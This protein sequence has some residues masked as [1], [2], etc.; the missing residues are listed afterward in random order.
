VKIAVVGSGIAGLSAAW[1]M[2]DTH[3]V[4]LFEADERLGGHSNTVDIDYDGCKLSVDTGF[5]VYNTLNY[6]NL[7]A[8]FAHLSV[9]TQRADMSFAFS[10]GAGR[11]WSSNGL[12]GVFAWRRNLARFEF[13]TMLSDIL[14]FS[15]RARLDLSGNRVDLRAPLG[16]YLAGCRVGEAFRSNYLLPMGSAIWSTPEAKLLEFPAQSFLRFFNN[17]RLFQLSRP[18]WRSVAGG[19]RTY[20]Q[21]MARDLGSRVHINSPVLGVTRLPEGVAI[22]TPHSTHRFDAAVLAGHSDQSLKV[23]RNPTL[24]QTQILSAI[25]FGD[26]VAYLHRDMSFMPKRRAAW[27]AWNYLREPASNRVCVTYWMNPLQGLPNDKPVFVTLNPTAPPDPAQTFSTI[28]Y[29][30][31][32]FDQAALAAQ[33]RIH[34]IQGK[35]NVWFA[36]AWLGYGFHEDGIVSG[37]R[38]AHELGAPI[39]WGQK[40]ERLTQFETQCHASVDLPEAA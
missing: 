30:H 14:R 1:A 19:S 21:R 15:L 9:E 7:T 3:D 25:K 2:R 39:P 5:I 28:H 18:K 17:H 31:P 37:L 20:V 12:A 38:I 8:L 11:E 16:E 33:Q 32:L 26:N 24:D 6:P 22:E 34:T 10:A 40:F 29:E 27:G 36:G 23:L 35:D 4:T 13:L